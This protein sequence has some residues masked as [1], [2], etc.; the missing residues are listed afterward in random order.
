MWVSNLHFVLKK[1]DPNYVGMLVVFLKER[2][3]YMKGEGYTL[4]NPVYLFFK[5]FKMIYKES[6]V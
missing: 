5:D 6:G 3:N 2:A 4:K 1:K